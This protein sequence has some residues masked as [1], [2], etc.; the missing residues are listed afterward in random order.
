MKYIKLALI[1][2]VLLFLLLLAITAFIPSV[3]RVS[4]AVNISAKQQ[5]IYPLLYNLDNWKKWNAFVADSALKQPVTSE[6]KIVDGGTGLVI[7]R[8]GFTDS[9]INTLWER[10]GKEI[11][12]GYNIIGGQGD[13]IVVQW[14]FD[15]RLKWYPWEKISSI[16]FDKQLGPLMD[17]SLNNL[18]IEVE[19]QE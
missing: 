9:T 4:R 14:Y 11:H 15:I 3:V 13:V 7:H 10:K 17:K 18:K 1:S 6:S 8:T 16:V 19:K 2:F 12:S 5:D